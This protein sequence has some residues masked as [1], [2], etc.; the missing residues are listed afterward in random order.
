MIIRKVTEEDTDKI[1]QYA[2]DF[3]SYYPFSL[4]YELEPLLHVLGGIA[5]TGIF[6]VAEDKEGEVLGVIGGVVVPHYLMPMYLIGQ[7]C[8]LWIEEKGRGKG[9]GK[10]LLR[11]F[12]EESIQMGCKFVNMTS[13]VL[14]P[15]FKTSLLNE[16]YVEVET[17]FLKEVV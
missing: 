13:T 7:E 11:A 8:F 5:T 1:V 17:S 2:Q 12:E 6:L 9:L 15:Q 3:M 14:T 16:G 4:D 10:T